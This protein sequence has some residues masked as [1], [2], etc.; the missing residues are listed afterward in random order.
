MKGV[1]L[2]RLA[3]AFIVLW[4]ASGLLAASANEP[5]LL[6]AK[7]L[8]SPAGP[9]A[10]EPFLSELEGGRVLMSWT[11]AAG[12]GFAVKVAIADSTGWSDAR[13]V[14]ES[15]ELFV[16]WADFPSAVAMADG[17]LVA[18]W[19]QINGEA[20]YQYDIR[21]AMSPDE[22][23]TW[24]PSFILHDDRSQREHGFA[25]LLPMPDNTVSAIWLDGQA[26]D[27]YAAQD[28]PENAMQL[29]ARSVAS[30]GRLGLET[31]LDSRTCTCCQTSAALTQSGAVLAAYRDR[32]S[33]EVRDIS[34]L[35]HQQNRWSAPVRVYD[36]GWVI[37]GCPVNG[38]AIDAS[39]G[40]AAVAWF[41]ASGDIPKVRVAF[42]DDD[43]VTFQSALQIDNGAPSGRVDIL[44]QPDGAAIVSWVE[45]TAK[46]ETIMICRVLPDTGCAKAFTLGAIP[47]GRT[48]GFPRMAFAKDAIVIAWTE[49]AASVDGSP[50]SGSNI[51][52]RMVPLTAFTQ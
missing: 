40:R 52:T 12:N 5:V 21:I 13:V 26:Y 33:T 49:P 37:S 43:G 51:R 3:L 25:T 45:R 1:K 14:V 24:G 44:Q 10:Q 30:D 11:E 36:D 17:T 2:Q 48:V 22:G 38:P 39:G 42:S 29:R 18:H 27:A 31:L 20:S 41:T 47:L 16:N 4:T 6:E 46:G 7:D 28:M 35:R 9:G 15:T 23:K 34:V 19:L 50:G 8:M 32:S